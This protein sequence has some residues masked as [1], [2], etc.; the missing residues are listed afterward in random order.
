MREVNHLKNI[1]EVDGLS[2]S[3][4]GKEAVLEDVTLAI[5]EGDYIGLT[6]PNGAGKTTLLRLMLGLLTPGS[7]T[8]RLFGTDIREFR[9]W[10]RIGYVPQKAMNFDLHFPA[11]V[12]EVVL[13]G[14]YAKRGLF[15]R[16]TADDRG[17][18]FLALDAVDMREYADRM[19]GDLSGGQ[20]QRVFIARALVCEP[21][22]MFLDEPTT[23][24][25]EDAQDEFYSLLQKLNRDL[26]LTI[27]LVSH[28]SERVVAEAM[29]IVCVNRTLTCHTSADE[30]L[31]QHRSGHI[32]I[33]TAVHRTKV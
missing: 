7:G 16:V 32:H 1:I 13:M 29:H 19:I 31:R 24:I 23:G 9:D 30:Y 21:E 15:H 2:F 18:V 6:G 10:Y 4:T 17:A 5:H 22:V 11:T 3:Y 12:R 25:D 20:Q 26:G 28:D 8:V 27:V 14:R 33:G